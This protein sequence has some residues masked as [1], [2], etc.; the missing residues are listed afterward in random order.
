MDFITAELITFL[1]TLLGGMIFGAAFMG[2][3]LVY[4]INNHDTHVKAL[5]QEQRDS[6]NIYQQRINANSKLISNLQTQKSADR[7]ELNGLYEIIKNS[8]NLVESPLLDTL[9]DTKN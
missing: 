2:C 5:K 4:V 3:L 1:V 7:L 9:G 8:N 6:Y